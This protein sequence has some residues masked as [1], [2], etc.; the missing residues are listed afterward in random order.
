MML[1]RHSIRTL[2]L[3]V[4]LPFAAY[5]ETTDKLQAQS[6][7]NGWQQGWV[8][9]ARSIYQA[10]QDKVQ[11][12]VLLVGDSISH[13]NPAQRWAR[14]GSGRTAED[15]SAIAY[16][17]LDS[18]DSGSDSNAHHQAGGYLA[19]AD[20]SLQRGMTASNGITTAEMLAGADNG[21]AAMPLVVASRTAARMVIAD[22]AS[23]IGNLHIKTLARAF[24][25]AEFAF[26]MLGTN[27][28]SKNRTVASII[29]DLQTLIAE[30][31]A[32]NIVVVLC[33][34]APR[35][36][37]AE[38]TAATISLN[39]AIR[40][41]AESQLLP[42]LDVE[43]EHMLRDPGG[44]ELLSSDGIHP[45]GT[46]GAVQA[47]SNPYL[48]NGDTETHR[49]GD[50][51]SKSGYLLHSWLRVQKMKEVTAAVLATVPVVEAS[52]PLLPLPIYAAVLVACLLLVGR[53]SLSRIN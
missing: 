42:L 49:T 18:W 4:C 1:S 9:R 22:G 23:Y 14:Q 46:N 48:P 13:A 5:A 44:L 45:S 30:L 37:S 32:M 15:L 35:V 3:Y 26:L 40:G 10:G 43:L 41:L 34:I 36:D 31:E 2:L 53:Y 27:D 39:T 12:K 52:T 20:T 25:D 17:H 19:A 28:V 16:T 38:N 47:S 11:G 33:T 51:A 24:E 50:N 6:H 29:A 8:L 7:D 21:G